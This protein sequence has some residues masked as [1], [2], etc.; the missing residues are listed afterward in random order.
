MPLFHNVYYTKIHLSLQLPLSLPPWPLPS[1]GRDELR[2][3]NR[4]GLH[5]LPRKIQMFSICMI[6]REKMEL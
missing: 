6:G 1:P 3:V 4:P 5:L 2:Y